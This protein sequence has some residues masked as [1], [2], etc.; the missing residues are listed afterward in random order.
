[1][2]K[3]QPGGSHTLQA[4]PLIALAF[5]VIL[6]LLLG[7]ALIPVSIVQRFRMGTMRRPARGWVATLNLSGVLIS[8]GMFTLASLIA[9][10]WA[11]HAFDYTLAGLAAGCALG[12]LGLVLIRWEHAAGRLYY[13][14]NR[15]LVLGVTLIVAVRVCYGLWRSWEAWQTSVSQMTWIAASGIAES[16]SAGAVVL[17]YY[18]VFWAGVR[19]RIGRDRSRRLRPI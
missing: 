7:V 15:W 1:V 10:R 19:W 17:G 16:M 8:V 6:I 11:A 14:P 13:T 4:V 12:V 9:S 5:L 3:P 18:L 2:S